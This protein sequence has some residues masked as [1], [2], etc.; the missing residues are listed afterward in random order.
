M[1]L[2]SHTHFL[3]MPLS[4]FFLLFLLNAARQPP[5]NFS[6]KQATQNIMHKTLGTKLTSTT[7]SMKIPR[8]NDPSKYDPSWEPYIVANLYLYVVPLSIFL[9]R[10]RELDFSP[11][12][13]QQ[14]IQM[15]QRV[16][17]VFS[18]DV[19]H[20]LGRHL[21]DAAD[22]PESTAPLLQRHVEL[23]GPFAPPTGAGSSLG[24]LQDDM[25]S[26]FEEIN[27]QYLKKKREQDIL[28]RMIATVEGWFGQ[29]PASGNEKTLM[30]LVERAKLIAGLPTEFE[31]LPKPGPANNNNNNAT[32][33]NTKGKPDGLR[34]GPER[35]ANGFL[36]EKG[37]HMVAQ[38]LV[39]CDLP[40]VLNRADKMRRPPRQHELAILVEWTIWA[41]DRWNVNL[42]FLA[43]YRNFCFCVLCV[44]LIF[45]FLLWYFY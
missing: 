19:I 5:K 39:H 4:V 6:P 44:Y 23:L 1:L 29:G 24:S 43:D 31:L 3:M 36:T 2:F 42:R 8:Y 28:D 45:K 15:V 10:A 21:V 7:R 16:F 12:K 11:A 33:T 18:P 13:F 30:L 32:S 25:Q 9:R 26:L 35:D 37:R 34:D 41:S 17:R 20:V 40:P 27:M 22:L 14:S 38:G